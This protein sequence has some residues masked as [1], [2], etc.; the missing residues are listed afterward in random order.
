MTINRKQCEVG[1]HAI[2]MCL[3]VVVVVLQGCSARNAKGLETINTV[4]AFTDTPKNWEKE[5]VGENKT[6]YINAD[7]ILPESRMLDNITLIGDENSATRMANELII[8]QYENVSHT[9]DWSWSVSSG[10]RLVTS[11]SLDAENWNAYYLDVE[12]DQSGLYCEEE[13]LFNYDHITQ[14]KPTGLEMTSSEAAEK[15]CNYFES[16]SELEFLPYRVLAADSTNNHGQGF[17]TVWAQAVCDG[18]PVCPRMDGKPVSLGVYAWISEEKI[19]SFQSV[20]LLKKDTQQEI[21]AIVPLDIVVDQLG[22][23]FSHFT[24]AVHVGVNKI[25]LEYYAL[26]NSDGSYKLRPVWSFYGES[27]AENNSVA[28][29][30][31]FSYFADDGTLCYAG[32]LF[33]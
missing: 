26:Q 23:S 12:A 21:S 2:L 20:F 30:W 31:L 15:V 6:L 7:I 16:F 17:Y 27:E 3:L 22:S 33:Y 18:I 1:R 13:F 28:M 32:P 8:S 29:D 10:D 19:F 24:D 4:Q 25:V 5:Y 9:S 11:F 14:V